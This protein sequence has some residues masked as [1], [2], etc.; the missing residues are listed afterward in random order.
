MTQQNW[1]IGHSSVS[2]KIFDHRSAA[3]RSK[4]ESLKSSGGKSK[5]TVEK[6]DPPRET[7]LSV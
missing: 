2:K 7:D 6:I 1:F 3:N 5:S 4:Q